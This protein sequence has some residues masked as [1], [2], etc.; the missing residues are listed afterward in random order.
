MKQQEQELKISLTQDQYQAL[1]GDA[2]GQVQ[3]NFYFYTSNPD[4]MVRIRQKNCVF[5][6]TVKRRISQTGGVWLCD[7]HNQTIDQKY[8]QILVDKGISAQILNQT[9]ELGLT[10]NFPFAGMLKTIRTK[11]Q[12]DQFLLEIDKNEYLGVCDFE[13]ECEHQSSQELQRLILML[14]QA[15]DIDYCPSLAKSQ[16]F[17]QRLKENVTQN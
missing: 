17:F 9:F 15:Y 7:E 12:F 13:L 16:R 8:A 5:Q 6:L 2:V 4:V 10:G 1:V 14:K 11:K 3:E